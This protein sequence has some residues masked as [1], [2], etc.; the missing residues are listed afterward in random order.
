MNEGQFLPLTDSAS[1]STILSRSETEPVIIFKHSNSCPIS[2]T[3]Y[4][5]M[6]KSKIP[7]SLIVVQEARSVS[8]EVESRTGVRHESPQVLIVRGGKVVWSASHG[9][10]KAA[11]VQKALEAAK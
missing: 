7:M 6:V 8:N 10:V 2:G 3:A 4:D 1:L 9:G 11:A 5:E